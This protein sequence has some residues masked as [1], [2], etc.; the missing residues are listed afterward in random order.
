MAGLCSAGWGWSRGFSWQQIADGLTMRVNGFWLG[1]LVAEGLAFSC[2]FP[3]SMV[4]TTTI[5]YSTSWKNIQEPVHQ[6]VI[7]QV[8]MVVT[9]ISGEAVV[10]SKRFSGVS[11]VDL[12]AR[13]RKSKPGEP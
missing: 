8:V 7:V 13:G 11:G 2:S 10:V 9:V 5:S 1:D 12:Q 6:V 4:S 3:T